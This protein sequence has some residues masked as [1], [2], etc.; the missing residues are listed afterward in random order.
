[1]NLW[2]DFKTNQGRAIHKHSHYF[3]AYERHFSPW[4]NKTMTFIEIGVQKGGSLEM[5]QRFFGPLATIV[6]I[7]IDPVCANYQ[8][9]GIHVRI[10]DQRDPAFLASIIDEFGAPDI[11]LDDGSHQMEHIRKSFE[12]FYPKLSKN[13]VYMV[14]D[15]HTAYWEEYGGGGDKPESFIN[16][17]KSFVDRLNADWTRGAVSPDFITQHTYAISF[18]DSIVAFE[19]GTVPD[20]KSYVI[21]K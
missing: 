18:Y 5:W 20:K 12:F 19:R 13:G 6:G 11:V 10:G 14:E 15:L 4:Q 16:I 8:G 1:M 3:P 2:Q 21:G 17:S 9:N 7:D